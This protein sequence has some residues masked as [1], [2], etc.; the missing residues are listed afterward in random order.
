MFDSPADG[1]PFGDSYFP[2]I[3]DY[4]CLS[5]CETTA[6][7]APDGGVQWLCLPRHPPLHSRDA[8][9]SRFWGPFWDHASY[10]TVNDPRFCERHIPARQPQKPSA[11]W[12]NAPPR[13]TLGQ[14]VAG[15]NLSAR[16]PKTRF[17]TSVGAGLC[18]AR[19]PC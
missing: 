12:V 9:A 11:N 4:A 5:D 8:P 10:A 3:E 1:S 6:L 15:S 7:V 14:V 2:P 13:F 18:V 16:R 17:L 19:V